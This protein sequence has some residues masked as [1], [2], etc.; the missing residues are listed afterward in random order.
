MI[1]GD[2]PSFTD[3]LKRHLC[4]SK[5]KSKNSSN[6]ITGA[7]LKLVTPTTKESYVERPHEQKFC[8]SACV[9]VSKA[10]TRY[11]NHAHINFIARHQNL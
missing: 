6:M 4:I 2:S 3:K 1:N 8:V 5:R 10:S 9:R 11:V 7:N